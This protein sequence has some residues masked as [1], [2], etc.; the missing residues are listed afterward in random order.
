MYGVAR[1]N[2]LPK[3]TV[4]RMKIKFI[5][6]IKGMPYA[7]VGLYNNEHILLFDNKENAQLYIN[8]YFS[9]NTNCKV[10]RIK[11]SDKEAE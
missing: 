7:S 11:V 1:R 6:T 2:T 9:K 4:N 8:S 3:R 5:I 10:R